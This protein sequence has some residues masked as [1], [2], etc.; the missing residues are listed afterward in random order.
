MLPLGDLGV[1]NGIARHFKMK[2]QGKNGQLE[3]KKDGE[4]IR[5]MLEQFH[6][7]RSV[8]SWYMWRALETESYDEAMR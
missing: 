2:G 5:T 1:R 7:Y 8:V 3:E 6:P 4:R